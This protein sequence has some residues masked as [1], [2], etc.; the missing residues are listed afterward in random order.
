MS[1]PEL[2]PSAIQFI[3]DLPKIELHIHIEGTLSPSLRWRLAHKNSISLPYATYDALLGSYTT[4]YNHRKEVHGDNGLPTFLEA[5]YG[6]MEVLRTED[7]FYDLAMEYFAKAKE[8]NVRYTDPFFDPQAHT[9]RGVDLGMVMR[10]LQRAKADAR[11][12]YDIE[13]DWTMCF[14]RDMSPESAMETYDAVISGGF[15]D[16][17]H[18]VG[19]DSNEYERPPSLFTRVFDKARKAGYKIT[20]HCDV[21]QKDTHEHILE[22]IS[23]CVGGTEGADRIDH[24]LNAVERPELMKAIKE[25]GLGL[26]LCP[27]A[28]HRRN[29]TEYVFGSIKRL[30]EEGILIAIASDDPTYMHQRWVQ[31]NLELVMLH[32]GFTEK[33]MVKLQRNA[34][35]ICWARDGLKNRIMAE[36][37]VVDQRYV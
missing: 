35:A 18:A 10:G 33:E 12:K 24:G 26:T 30:W 1:S 32:C 7:D 9:R 21:G 14:L 17:F 3:A 36:L 34:V 20:A 15:G 28:Y 8:M 31:E 23:T 22:V 37:D 4:M 19:L 29:S 16:I 11:V 27:H 25:R 5:Y 6:G 2:S 13:V